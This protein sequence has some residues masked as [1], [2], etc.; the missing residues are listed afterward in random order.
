MWLAVRWASCSGQAVRTSRTR[1]GPLPLALPCAA[2]RSGRGR[3]CSL[4]SLGPAD[5]CGNCGPGPAAHAAFKQP[6]PRFGSGVT[7]PA[8]PGGISGMSAAPI[9][10]QS[11]RSECRMHGAGGAR[12]ARRAVGHRH[13]RII[14]YRR[15][16]KSG[17]P[18]AAPGAGRAALSTSR[19]RAQARR[20][21]R[22]SLR[23]RCH[24]FP[25]RQG[26]ETRPRR[27]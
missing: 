1:H 4:R 5:R 17:R 10:P 2:A 12:A 24:G 13:R 7:R 21:S 14:T 20:R 9:A 3:R 18:A 15:T 25:Q 11:T 22:H 27:L 16:G 26:P 6:R 23:L 19:V 8:F